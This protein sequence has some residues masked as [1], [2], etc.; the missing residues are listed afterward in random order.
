MLTQIYLHLLKGR[1]LIFMLTIAY[2]QVPVKSNVYCLIHNKLITLE[3]KNEWISLFSV[4]V[5]PLLPCK[6]VHNSMETYALPY[7][8][9]IAGGNLLCDTGS[10]TQCSVTTQ[11]GGMGC[12]MGGRVK[13]TKLMYLWRIHIDIQQRPTQYCKA[14]MLQLKNRKKTHKKR[15]VQPL[16]ST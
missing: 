13:T 6:Q 5:S 3:K 10:S 9:Q 7:V 14:I 11:G 8:K 12:E 1:C 15:K 4:S 2:V 16:Y